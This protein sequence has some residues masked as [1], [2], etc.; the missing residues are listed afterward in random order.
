MSHAAFFE[1]RTSLRHSLGQSL[2][3]QSQTIRVRSARLVGF[4]DSRMDLLINGWICLI[5]LAGLAKVGAATA[6]PANIGDA[7]ALLLPY[8]LIALAPIAGYRITTGSFPRGVLTAQPEIRLARIGKWRP[9]DVISARTNPAYGPI[10]FMASLL[11]GILLNVPT[12]TLE[13]LAAVPAVVASAPAWAQTYFLF[14]T[15]D[16]IVMNFF[17]MV[18][19][20]LALR[21][22][23]LFPRMLLFA[24]AFDIMMQLVI[25]HRLA[26]A[27]ALPQEIVEP[28]VTLL[29]GNITKVLISAFVWL[30]YVILSERVNVTYRL[31]TAASA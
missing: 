6:L 24:W 10:G 28:L 23:P 5:V 16:V 18:C 20:V 15:A 4:L 25:A 13:Y 31:R 9:L 17:Y 19:F 11:V 21:S 12:R 3:R 30:P 14:M 22:N 29:R 26:A 7:L 8:L 1:R 27:P 2:T